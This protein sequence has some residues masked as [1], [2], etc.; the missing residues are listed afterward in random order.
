MIT[1]R[2]LAE[3]K[4]ALAM[5]Q[6]MAQNIMVGTVDGDIYYVRNGRVPV[7]PDRLRSVQAH[8]REPASA[9]GKASIRSKT[10]PQIENPP[11]GYMQNCNISP[12]A[13][14]KDSPLTPE[15]FAAHPYLYNAAAHQ[16][17]SGLPWCWTCW[18]RHTDVTPEQA[19]AIAFSPEI[20]K[21]DLW[22]D[23][24]RKSALGGRVRTDHSRLEPAER[25]RFTGRPRVLPFQDFAGRAQ[26]AGRAAGRSQRR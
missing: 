12:L 16:R 13:M 19:I 17:I 22:Q 18:L 26:Q 24:I 10:W 15:K 1:A 3:M 25:C 5:L 21:A 6:L 9:N 2:N 14:M 11:Q 23:R 7:R 8:A 20:C 4:K